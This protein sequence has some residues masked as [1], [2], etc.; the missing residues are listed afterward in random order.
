[1]PLA[2]EDPGLVLRLDLD[3]S[4]PPTT[5]AM[6]TARS[7]AGAPSLTQALLCHGLVA[8]RD[9]PWLAKPVDAGYVWG[10][11]RLVVLLLP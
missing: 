6:M 3:P 7:S 1:M 8:G 9:F 5:A 10:R 4:I 2:A 11:A